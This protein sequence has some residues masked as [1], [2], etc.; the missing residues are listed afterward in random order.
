M[1]TRDPFD[2]RPAF[3]FSVLLMVGILAGRFTHVPSRLSLA[4][5][6]LFFVVAVGMVVVKGPVMLR[7]LSIVLTIVF[8]GWHFQIRDQDEWN[9]NLVH[10]VAG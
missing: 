5:L 3:R 2:T 10:S 6:V 7:D 8:V 4:M 1:K 9:S